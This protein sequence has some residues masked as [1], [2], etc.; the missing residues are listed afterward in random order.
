MVSLANS[1]ALFR[2]KAGFCIGG[3]AFMAKLAVRGV[4]WIFIVLRGEFYDGND[5]L[6]QD[7][8]DYVPVI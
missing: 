4:F 6:P 5:R 8:G 2:L 1:T 3:D 7:D